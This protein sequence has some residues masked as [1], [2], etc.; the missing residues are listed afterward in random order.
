M[1]YMS[2]EMKKAL[3][4]QIKKVLK[5]YG[6]KGTL[7]VQH[8]SGL[9]VK[10]PEGSI[11]FFNSFTEK[12]K[13]ERELNG[14]VDVNVYWVKDHYEGIAKD[15][16]LEL[17]QAMNAT[18][19]GSIANHN[20]S[21][22]M[23]DYFDVGWYTYIKIGDWDKPYVYN[24]DMSPAASKEKNEVASAHFTQDVGINVEVR[25]GTKPGFSE[26]VFDEKPEQEILDSL[27]AAGF[28]WNFKKGVW[29]GKTEKIPF[30]NAA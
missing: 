22:Y 21:D 17:H 5:K 1:A 7:S 18:P 6:M 8:Y 11:D 10:L 12:G 19:D 4:P 29:W 9:V 30:D 24:P 28:R 23:T 27:K 3:A 20:R 25:E 13:P 16:L 14:Y 26:I 15:F 2:Q